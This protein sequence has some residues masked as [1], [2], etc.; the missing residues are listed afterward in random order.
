M[1][2][3]NLYGLAWGMTV[4]LL[5]FALNRLVPISDEL[6]VAAFVLLGSAAGCLFDRPGRVALVGLPLCV[7]G[8]GF[9]VLVPAVN[10]FNGHPV[11]NSP[12]C[13]YLWAVGLLNFPLLVV[14]GVRQ[15]RNAP[16]EAQPE[17]SPDHGQDPGGPGL[18]EADTQQSTEP[19]SQK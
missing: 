17:R 4:G 10:Y 12:T 13:H 18:N 16:A 6:A 14:L 7:W 3:H 9:A 8:L 19:T 11:L 5:A 1:I 2:F 15:A